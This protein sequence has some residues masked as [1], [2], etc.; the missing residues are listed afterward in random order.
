MTYNL[1]SIKMDIKNV[2]L[3]KVVLAFKELEFWCRT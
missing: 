2:K 1:P 3:G